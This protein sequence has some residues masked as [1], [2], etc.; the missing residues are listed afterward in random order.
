[1]KSVVVENNGTVIVPKEFVEKIGLVCGDAVSLSMF[2]NSLHL[3][4]QVLPFDP[5]NNT[6]TVSAALA[7]A[8]KNLSTPM[9]TIKGVGA[10]LTQLLEKR[11]VFTVEDALYLLPHRYEDRRTVTPIS[12]LKV[13]ESAVFTGKV[14]AADIVVTKGGRSYF[15]ATIADDSGTITFKW[16]SS[17]PTFLKR[18][19]L[20]G[21]SGVFTGEVSQ[22]NYQREVHHP[23]VVWLERGRS[24]EDFLASDSVDFGRIVPVY[25]LTDGLSQKVMRKIMKSVVE[26]YLP[27]LTD[28]IPES[29]LKPFAMPPLLKS[30]Y[31]LHLPPVDA[32]I[33]S[34]NLGKTLEHR[35]VVFD[36]F[37]YWELG[38]ALKRRGIAM[39][40]GIGFQVSHRYTK[41]LLKLLPFELTDAQRRVLSEIKQDMISNSPM[42]RLVQ[43][44]VGS[45]KTLV[46]LMAALIAVE[47]G[48][49]VA[50]MAPTE[51]LAEQHWLTIHGWCSKL[52]IVTTLLTSG[53][54]GT[55]KKEAL[56]QVSDGIAQIVVGTHAVIQEKVEFYK[57]G[58]GI[59]DEQHRF[60]VLQRGV[61]KKK[62]L[63]PDILVM[64]ATPIPRTLAMTLF[65][66]LALSLIDQL[67]PGRTPIETRIYFESRRK[68]LYEEIRSEVACGHQVYI[69]YPLVAETEKSDLRAAEQMAEQLSTQVFPD[70]RINLIHGRMSPEEK[71]NVMAQ[72]KGRHIDILVATTVIEVGIDVPNA[73]MMV[74]EHSER[75]GLSQLHQLRGRVG[76]GTASSRCI[77]MT[78]DKL[79][80]EARKRLQVMVDTSDGFRIAEADLEIRGPGD[81]L[82][83]RQSGLPDFKVANILR[84]AALLEQSQKAALQLLESDPELLKPSNNLLKSELLRRWGKRLE[85][86]TVA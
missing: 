41:P 74:I 48:Y 60:G 28:Y 32:E 5:H 13:G 9:S 59:I 1:M 84:D 46:A 14:A 34:L 70:L 68:Q 69:I 54:K 50:I 67:P 24:V 6:E 33:E 23:E 26:N 53:M 57:L 4:R 10:K 42:H 25:P 43:G 7:I 52:G 35:S 36:E 71:E 80:K 20:V 2:E 29:V 61:L 82:G 56:K 18:V 51:I 49:Q 45:G 62:G 86:G 79:S 8:R 81:F 40:K 31:F 22:F 64:T 27:S 75:F 15:E 11:G 16:F 47:N 38:L 73:T 17:N 21:K 44:D 66:D 3:T 30:L 65:G 76:R 63:N 55:C 37:F 83:T 39:E 72:F 19:W 78:G 77:L 58:L 12:L 85:L